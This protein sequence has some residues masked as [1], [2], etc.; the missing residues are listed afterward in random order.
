MPK[1][2]E[3]GLSTRD[4]DSHQCDLQLKGVKTVEVLYF[5]DDS[6]KGRKI[7]TGWGV[8]GIS[9]VF[10]VVPRKAIPYFTELTSRRF[11]T[12]TQKKNK[13][14]GD[15]TEPLEIIFISLI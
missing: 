1:Y 6:Y 13:T 12:D 15:F 3:S 4:F 7:V 2:C 5:R 11:L 9:Y 14:D 10:E 8:D